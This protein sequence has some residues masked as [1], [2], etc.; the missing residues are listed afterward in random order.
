MSE[1]PKDL[2]FTG[3]DDLNEGIKKFADRANAAYLKPPRPAYVDDRANE[4]REDYLAAQVPGSLYRIM[5]DDIASVWS[6]LES[7]IEQIAIFQ[8]AAENYS[9]KEGWPIYA[10]V[11]KARGLHKHK[12]YPV[13][14]I[15][16]VEF[17]RARVDFLFDLGE[18]GLFAIECDGKEFHADKAKDR[19]RDKRLHE[20]HGVIVFRIEGRQLWRDNSTARAYADIIR[21]YLR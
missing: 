6:L 18:R 7:P 14:L 9:S 13:Q 12:H 17:G 2:D 19:A 20:E 5:K 8:L 3:F 11:C 16:Q 1:K 4:A 15:P 10:K 21:V